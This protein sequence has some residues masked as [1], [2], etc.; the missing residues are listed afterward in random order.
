M[1]HTIHVMPVSSGRWSATI[2]G[3]TLVADSAAP[4]QDAA[5]ALRAAGAHDDDLV[6]ADGDLPT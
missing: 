3:K 1:K 5:R 6:V 4:I 2:A